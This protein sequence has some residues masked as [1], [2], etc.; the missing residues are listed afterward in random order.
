MRIYKSLIFPILEIKL[1]KGKTFRG[2]VVVVLVSFYAIFPDSRTLS[3]TKYE[4]QYLSREKL[5]K[6]T[7]KLS[8][9]L[10][11]RKPL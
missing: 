9:H 4:A 1:H 3:G 10:G 7:H 2:F 5:N 8:Y 6:R 11:N